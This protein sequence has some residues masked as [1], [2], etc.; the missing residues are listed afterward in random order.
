[1]VW[2]ETVALLILILLLASRIKAPVD[3]PAWMLG[4]KLVEGKLM[5][6]SYHLYKGEVMSK[7]TV[8]HLRPN[9]G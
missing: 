4:I 7:E 2:R 3:V 1:M 9:C 6:E 5:F 8:R